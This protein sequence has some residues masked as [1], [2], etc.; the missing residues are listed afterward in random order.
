[1][2]GVIEGFRWTVLGKAVPGDWSDLVASIVV[3]AA[4]LASGVWYFRRTERTFA[5]VI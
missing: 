5:D 3:V 2:V 4:V 1:M